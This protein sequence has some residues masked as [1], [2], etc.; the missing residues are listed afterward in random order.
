M[1]N[2]KLFAPRSRTSEADKTRKWRLKKQP[3][4]QTHRRT[5]ELNAMASVVS[6]EF[7]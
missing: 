6:W 5:I 2:M 4:A 1:M 7:F 3:L